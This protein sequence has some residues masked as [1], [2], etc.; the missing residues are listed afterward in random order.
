MLTI[1]IGVLGTIVGFYFGAAQEAEAPPPSASQAQTLTIAPIVLPAGIA[2]T[3]YPPTT[4]RTNGGTSP[5]KWSVEPALPPDLT[6]NAETGEISGIPTAPSPM[7]KF[8]FSVT[9]SST[10]PVSSNVE[11][12]M[13]I[14]PS[15]DADGP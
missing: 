15:A 3:A 10:P 6:L 8:T 7:T 13:E 12:A 11:L 5:L 1:L 14:K 2:K 4:L 9:D